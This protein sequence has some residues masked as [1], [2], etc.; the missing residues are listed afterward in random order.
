MI[1]ASGQQQTAPDDLVIRP[2]MCQI[3][4][5]MLTCWQCVTLH[6]MLNAVSTRHNAVSVLAGCCGSLVC[7]QLF[8]VQHLTVI[9]VYRKARHLIRS[10]SNCNCFGLIRTIPHLK[11][12]FLRR[13]RTSR[14]IFQRQ[15]AAMAYSG[16]FASHAAATIRQQPY[17]IIA[18]SILGY[19]L[20]IVQILAL[21]PK[22][23]DAHMST[24][25]QTAFGSWTAFM[26]FM[27]KPGWLGR[28]NFGPEVKDLHDIRI[29]FA[30]SAPGK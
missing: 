13:F 30:Q 15:S 9:F 18:V 1:M 3:S 27:Q 24:V 28:R 17:G 11:V 12:Y 25:G 23:H 4:L 2:C 10:P 29:D 20:E 21:R 8:N 19:S 22:K 6:T 14:R 16:Y 5:P 26:S 7:L